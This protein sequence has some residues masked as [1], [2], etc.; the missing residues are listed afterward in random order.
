MADGIYSYATS[1]GTRYYFK[2]RKSDGVSA[3]KRGFASPRAARRARE[4]L[5]VASR[6]G[7]VSSAKETLNGPGKTAPLWSLTVPLI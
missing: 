3:T 6:R 4:Q 7:Q 5:E 1:Q 2:Y